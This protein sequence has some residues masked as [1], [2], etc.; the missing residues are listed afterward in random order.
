MADL[1]LNC[2]TKIYYNGHFSKLHVHKL[3]AQCVFRGLVR[4]QSTIYIGY[5]AA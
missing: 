1:E 2:V 3:I 4:I 5:I